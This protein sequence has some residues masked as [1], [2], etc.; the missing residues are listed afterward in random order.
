MAA[1]H[2]HALQATLSLPPERLGEVCR[3]AIFHTF[4]SVLIG[5][6]LS[7]NEAS[8]LAL[9]PQPPLKQWE[10]RIAAAIT[11]ATS[12]VQNCSFFISME[13]SFFS[14][15]WPTS[16][17]ASPFSWER[18][19]PF[20]PTRQ[21]LERVSWHSLTGHSQIRQPYRRWKPWCWDFSD[22]LPPFLILRL[23]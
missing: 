19:K 8:Q 22:R 7:K 5:G 11:S 17:R 1:S 18:R 21:G 14:P 16:L 10:Q 9:H 12:H 13:N 4:I 2:L 6:L 15:I 20:W 23:W 3:R